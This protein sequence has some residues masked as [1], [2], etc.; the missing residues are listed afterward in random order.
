MVQLMNIFYVGHQSSD[1]LAGVGLGNMLLNVLVFAVTM[2]LNGTIETFV[3]W[4]LGHDD[5]MLCGLHLNRA[6]VIVTTFLIPIMILFC[7][8]DKILIGLQQ[9]PEIARIAH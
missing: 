3:A 1:L 2:G 4:S 5:K 9:D 8:M 6:R 7:F